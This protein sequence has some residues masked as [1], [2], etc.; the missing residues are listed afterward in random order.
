MIVSVNKIYKY[1]TSKASIGNNNTIYIVLL[2]ITIKKGTATRLRSRWKTGYCDQCT[3]R[4]DTLSVCFTCDPG[5]GRADSRSEGGGRSAVTSKENRLLRFY[6][7]IYLH[8]NIRRE[9]G[10]DIRL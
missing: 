4:A 2:L 9:G 6:N 10:S 7:T 8:Q 5:T 3:G 1:D